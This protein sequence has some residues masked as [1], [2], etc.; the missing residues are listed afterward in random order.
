MK[1]VKLLL[2]WSW[3]GAVGA[4]NAQVV[5]NASDFPSPGDVWINAN[6]TLVES[7]DVGM[8]GANQTWDISVG[9]NTDEVL[10][11]FFVLP[12][13]TPWGSFFP[14]S[15]I[16]VGFPGVSYNY[17]S[18]N[19]NRALVLGFAGLDPSG[20]LDQPLVIPFDDPQTVAVFPAQMGVSYVDTSIITVI[21]PGDGVNFDSVRF[22]SVSIDTVTYDGWGTLTTPE[23]TYTDVLRSHTTTS[24][25]DSLWAYFFGVEFLLGASVTPIESWEWVS[26]AT[27]GPVATATL[28]ADT[29]WTVSW[30][31]LS[32]PPLAQF[33]YMDQGNGQFQ[34]TDQS[35]ND[36]DA[37]QWDF[38]DGTSSTEQNPSH[39][40]T[41]PGDYTV[42]LVVSNDAG[43]DTACMNITVVLPPVAAFTYTDEGGGTFNFMDQSTNDPDTWQWD[44]GD[45]T[46]STEQNP[47]HTFTTSG[48][49][50][51]CL[52]VSNSAGADSTCQTLQVV[53]TGLTE[54]W[55]HLDLK[56]FPNPASE[57]IVL[58]IN[59]AE[60][61]QF[62]L[63]DLS[64]RR[65]Y[66]QTFAETLAVGVR[67]LPKGAY[68]YTLR[69]PDGRLVARGKVMVVH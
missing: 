4:L 16:A 35:L 10:T 55:K 13:T 30:S 43:T 52:T 9:L 64:G 63:F 22:K 46:S 12:D 67:D 61:L 62:E 26:A 45:G 6:D 60:P 31:L 57:Q 24:Q 14:T 54:A 50:T 51:V 25:I 42:C 33:S 32:P 47:S 18:I 23:G 29:T 44:F 8:P 36:P 56:L 41:A 21:I 38:G 3:L 11:Q 59:R 58:T 48:D 15:N 7:V 37:W 5:L 66:A 49:Y 39:T 19:A 2:L 68:H 40:Y 17:L 1:R 65:V 34:F 27:K 53:V 28:N 20:T 69:T